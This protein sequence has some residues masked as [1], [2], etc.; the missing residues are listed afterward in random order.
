MFFLSEFFKCQAI[1]HLLCDLPIKTIVLKSI[2]STNTYCKELA[3][4]TNKDT[5]VVALSQTAGRGRLGRSFHSPK[6]GVYFSLL[7]H[8]SK[9][10]TDNLDLTTAAAVAAA[11]SCEKISGKK[12][13]IKWV[14][15]IFVDDK[16][17]CGIL[18]E[19]AAGNNGPYNDYV[20]IGIGVNV[21][22]P[23]NG[24]PDEIKDIATSLFSSSK[25]KS[26]IK[27]KLIKNI[28]TLL[29]DYIKDDTKQ[30]MNEYKARSYLDG[31][32]V[33]FARNGETVTATVLG[34]DN[35]AKLLLKTE[36]G[37]EL[38]LFAGEVSVQ[39]V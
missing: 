19:A 22:T 28:T 31:K 20:I 38:S 17:A 15:D 13:Y 16:K 12:A 34:I 5:L 33:C 36:D 11:V 23:K 9:K 6:A 7:L 18:T 14:N 25:E 24:F 8:P 27:A 10:A 26:G 32:K 21:F 2:D 3:K 39:R 29:L 4:N 37:E 35:D 1:K 30:F